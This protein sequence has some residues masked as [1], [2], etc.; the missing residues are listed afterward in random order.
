MFPIFKVEIYWNSTKHNSYFI[1]MHLRSLPSTLSLSCMHPCAHT[2]ASLSFTQSV[3]F[4]KFLLEYVHTCW[5]I[6]IYIP[7]CTHRTECIWQHLVFRLIWSLHDTVTFLGCH[8]HGC[9]IIQYRMHGNTL[10]Q[11]VPSQHPSSTSP[12]VRL[13][14]LPHALV[15]HPT[16][17]PHWP[18]STALSE[19][20]MDRFPCWTVS[21]V[22]TGSISVCLLW[23]QLQYPIE[24]GTQ[25][26]S[27]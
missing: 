24:V 1:S 6:Q 17:V 16:Y 22:K 9:I 26:V 14:C 19:C 15:Q 2:R 4:W 10:I 7:R 27:M 18:H 5:Y 25:Q 11:S 12:P 8:F 21:C 3:S 23:H 13:Y 20:W